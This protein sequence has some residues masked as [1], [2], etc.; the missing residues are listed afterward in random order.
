M[1]SVQTNWPLYS[2]LCQ[3]DLSFKSHVLFMLIIS[4]RRIYPS[5]SFFME[6]SYTVY[7]FLWWKLLG[8]G[9]HS[10]RQ[11]CVFMWETDVVT[12]NK[13]GN[14]VAY[15]VSLISLH[16]VTSELGRN[17][18]LL[19]IISPNTIKKLFHVITATSFDNIIIRN[20]KCDTT[21]VT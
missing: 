17:K 9:L 20:W 5:P 1:T 13:E 3:L 4:Y 6:F 14:S 10:Y 7:S 18:C 15:Y 19:F 12:E 8:T 21:V 16:R 2:V 11:N